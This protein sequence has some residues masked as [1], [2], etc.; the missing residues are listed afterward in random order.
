MNKEINK[1]VF[2]RFVNL[3]IKRVIHHY[4]V[5]AVISILFDEI[6][7]DLS[8]GKDIKIFNFGNLSL[9]STK[10]R[11][12]YDVRFNKIMESSGNKILK[13][14]LSKKLRTK[15]ISYICLDEDKRD[16]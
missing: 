3:K 10:P 8:G 9:K 14:S 15:L 6:I 13:F 2:W 12:Y 7:K 1:R 4:H 16:D 5:F 11:K